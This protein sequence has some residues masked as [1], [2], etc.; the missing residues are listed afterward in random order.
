[1]ESFLS[2]ALKLQLA[3]NI[4]PLISSALI[5]TIFDIVIF[6]FSSNPPYSHMQQKE[7]RENLQLS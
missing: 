2:Y 5:S 4:F 6:P 3:Y 7:G 1:M